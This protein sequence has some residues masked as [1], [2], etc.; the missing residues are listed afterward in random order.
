LDG[1]QSDVLHGYDERAGHGSTG[2]RLFTNRQR[3]TGSA[4]DLPGKGAEIS[5]GRWN[6]KGRPVYCASSISLAVLE[7]VVHIEADDL[8]PNRFVVCIRVPDEVWAARSVQT[9]ASLPIGWTARPEG[10]VSLDIGD[11][12]LAGVGFRR[13]VDAV[14]RGTS[15]RS[16][17]RDWH[18]ESVSR[19][20][21]LRSQ[22]C[23]SFSS[24]SWLRT[25]AW[26][27][28]DQDR[29]SRPSG[30]AA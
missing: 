15:E 14:R 8:P 28:L 21:P 4:P 17:A 1:S 27:P 18:R 19:A 11:A 12:W 30:R 22:R 10:K 2:L 6:R 25:R 5:G 9:A 29:R 16:A 23:R 13:Q 3:S 24:P 7:T 26:P 20:E